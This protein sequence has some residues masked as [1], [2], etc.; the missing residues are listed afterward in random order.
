MAGPYGIIQ[1]FD[2]LGELNKISGTTG[3]LPAGV[4]LGQPRWEGGVSYRLFCNAG[5]SAIAPGRAF[6]PIGSAGPYSVTITTT[7]KTFDH[8]GAG[9][10]VNATAATGFYFWGAVGGPIGGVFGDASSV[11][12]G[13]AFYIGSDG[14]V[15]LFPQSA[16][17]GNAA[18]GINLGGAATKT[19][20]T[21]T[22]S[23][24]V[25]IFGL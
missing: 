12:T 19:V 22:K 2:S 24:D 6:A 9:F 23:G 20:T 17:T 16:M 15:E 18:I 1:H 25:L 11:P 3:T 10:V 8:I 4:A 7:S 21:G 13:S 5:N 14:A